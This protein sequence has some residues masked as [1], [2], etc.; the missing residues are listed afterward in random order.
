MLKGAVDKCGCNLVDILEVR[1]AEKRKELGM[2]R[3][4]SLSGSRI[5]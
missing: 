1:V 2:W 5:K 4:G 3:W